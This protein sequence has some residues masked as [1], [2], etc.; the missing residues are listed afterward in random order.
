MDHYYF[1]WII[2]EKSFLA[3]GSFLICTLLHRSLVMSWVNLSI[4]NFFSCIT[5]QSSTTAYHQLWHQK[6]HEAQHS[7][8]NIIIVDQFLK[9]FHWNYKWNS[10]N[11][12]ELLSEDVHVLWYLNISYVNMYHETTNTPNTI[13]LKSSRVSKESMYSYHKL[14]WNSLFHQTQGAT[15]D[16]LLQKWLCAHGH[17]ATNVHEHDT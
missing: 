3:N 10:W 4:W 11:F 1:D 12:H 6:Q 7:T 14:L 13:T 17:R 15:N 16:W 9:M 5:N 8:L 2:E